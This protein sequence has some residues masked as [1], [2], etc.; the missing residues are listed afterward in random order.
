MGPA[1]ALDYDALVLRWMDR[2][3]RG[4]QNGVEDEPPVR[5]YAMGAGAWRTGDRWP[6][7]SERRA[8]YLHSAARPGRPAGRLSWDRAASHDQSSIMSDPGRPVV[9]LH[10]ES[11][12]PHDYRSLN[13]R[14]DVLVFETDPLVADVEVVGPVAARLYVSTDARDTD[15]WVKLLD[16]APDGTAFNLMSPGLDVVRASYREAKPERALLEPNTIY[17]VD[18]NTLL[19]GN[20]FLRG[21]RIRVAI[22]TSFAPHMSRNLHTGALETDSSRAVRARVTLHHGGDYPSRLDM[23]VVP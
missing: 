11:A 17:A 4:L 5:V 3:V 19:T 23:T 15:L 2:W 10:A 13:D 12:G 1:A 20:R 14:D 21:H 22:M 16:V 18:L 8:L 9:D 7:S 6:I